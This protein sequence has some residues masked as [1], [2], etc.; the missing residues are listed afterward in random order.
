MSDDTPEDDASE[1]VMVTFQ[2]PRAE[3]DALSAYA[4][5]LDLTR[6]QLLRQLVRSVLDVNQGRLF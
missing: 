6:S 5:T 3:R 2:I 4:A 1:V